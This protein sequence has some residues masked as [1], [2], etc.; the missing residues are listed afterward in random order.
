MHPIPD[1]VEAAILA[2]DEWTEPVSSHVWSVSSVLV[3]PRSQVYMID[4][5]DS[6]V[7][8][9]YKV[10]PPATDPAW[11]ERNVPLVNRA[12]VLLADH[13]LEAAPILA[14]SEEHNTVVTLFIPGR[15]FEPLRATALRLSESDRTIYYDIGRACRILETVEPPFEDHTVAGELWR[16]FEARLAHAG[17][18]ELDLPIRELASRSL[19]AA[20][21]ANSPFVQ[22]HKEMS[23]INV[24]IDR[25]RP[26]FIDLNFGPALKG[27]T[28]TKIVNRIELSTHWGT[29]ANKQAIEMVWQGHGVL[30][31]GAG[32]EFLVIDRLIRALPTNRSRV[33]ASLSPR[34]RR[35]MANL[36][37][38]LTEK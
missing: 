13:G 36:K 26:G 17:L 14:V 28:V 6:L 8:M 35:A 31:E 37:S 21:A 19:D 5:Q 18:D 12:V 2:L 20:V 29:P 9:V 38:L 7:R 30:P 23:H 4:L 15:Q 1:L 11:F 10:K 3:L 25:G 27:Y 32:R 22:V 34:R 16:R 24:V 33:R